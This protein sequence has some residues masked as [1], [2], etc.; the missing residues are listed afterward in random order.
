MPQLTRRGA[1]TAKG[2]TVS[3]RGNDW[4]AAGRTQEV[5]AMTEAEWLTCEAP[6]RMLEEVEGNP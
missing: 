2:G 1:F 4:S 5:R 3:S 6:D